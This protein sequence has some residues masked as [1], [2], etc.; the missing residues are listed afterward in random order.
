VPHQISGS[1][2]RTFRVNAG[3][4]GSTL[5][6][7]QG[8]A[9]RGQRVRR[10]PGEAF[11]GAATTS[12]ASLTGLATQTGYGRPAGGLGNAGHQSALTS[13]DARLPDAQMAPPSAGMAGACPAPFQPPQA[14]T[15]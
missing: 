1:N 13:T 9:R 5:A 4:R 11:G 3:L 10:A 15:G 14:A 12:L 2:M 7:W 8:D 6:P